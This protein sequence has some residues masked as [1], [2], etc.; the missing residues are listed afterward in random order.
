[1][2]DGVFCETPVAGETFRAVAFGEISVIQAGGVPAFDA[3]F[4]AVAALVHLHGDPLSD[5]ELVDAWPQRGHGSGI[6]V[7]HD[8]LTCRLPLE[9]PVQDLYVGSADRSDIHPQ[10]NLA[11]AELRHRTLLHPHIIGVV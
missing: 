11:V 8:E 3:V 7:A 9:R 4:A 2:I 6:L 5:L 1:M 10:E